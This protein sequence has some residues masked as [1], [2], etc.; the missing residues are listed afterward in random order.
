MNNGTLDS[1][2]EDIIL[3]GVLHL[4][5]LAATDRYGNVRK[6]MD[7]CKF[8]F[9]VRIPFYDAIVIITGKTNLNRCRFKFITFCSA[10]HICK[11]HHFYLHFE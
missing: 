5:C 9:L 3:L 2:E 11:V 1:T 10:I 6:A 4:P 7:F 8:H